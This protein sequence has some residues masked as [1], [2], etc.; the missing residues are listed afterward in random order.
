MPQHWASAQP[1][2]SR[3]KTLSAPPGACPQAS[4][5]SQ[6]WSTAQMAAAPATSCTRLL[7]HSRMQLPA[8]QPRGTAA[9]SATT[10]VHAAQAG[11]GS[12]RLHSANGPS[13]WGRKSWSAAASTPCMRCCHRC[14]CTGDEQ[15]EVEAYFRSSNALRSPY[16]LGLEKRGTLYYWTDGSVVNNGNVSNNSPYAHFSWTFQVRRGSWSAR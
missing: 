12:E 14:C 2:A 15:L 13:R 4:R 8:V 3:L 16:W 6:T 1:P 5:W 7:A 9:S 11:W 10:Q